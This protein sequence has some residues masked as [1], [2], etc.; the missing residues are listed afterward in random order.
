MCLSDAPSAPIHPRLHSML[1]KQSRG[2]GASKSK[3]PFGRK[4]FFG[5]PDCL[6]D[7]RTIFCGPSHRCVPALIRLDTREALDTQIPTFSI[8]PQLS[9]SSVVRAGPAGSHIGRSFPIKAELT[10]HS[11]STL[12]AGFGRDFRDYRY[13]HAKGHE[14]SREDASRIRSHAKT[15][16][17][18]DF[19]VE[20]KSLRLSSKDDVEQY[21]PELSFV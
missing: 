5:L 4:N 15:Q 21:T 20:D 10:K 13:F 19:G 7:E 18:K 12:T 16:R 6:L 17:R 9:N 8:N 14:I 3:L 11:G 2:T 1:T